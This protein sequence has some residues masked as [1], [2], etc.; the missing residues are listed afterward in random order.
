MVSRL[1]D[2]VACLCRRRT[3][4]RAAAGRLCLGLRDFGPW[5]VELYRM[6][7]QEGLYLAQFLGLP[8]RAGEIGA[9]RL[10]HE[11]LGMVDMVASGSR[12]FAR[13][14]DDGRPCALRLIAEQRDGSLLTASWLPN[15][16]DLKATA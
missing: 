8:E 7:G 16:Q 4:T 1:A 9:L 10:E 15:H 3:V 5:W 11:T 13:L 14:P 12:Y 2:G 6:P